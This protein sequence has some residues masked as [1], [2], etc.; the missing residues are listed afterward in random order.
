[1][2]FYGRE[3]QDR[4]A[5]YLIGPKGVFLDIGCHHPMQANNTM[6]LE[7]SGWDGL[8]F[9]LRERWVNLCKQYRRSEVFCVDAST[10]QFTDI[11]DNKLQSKLIDY[12]SLDADDG[13]L[14]A[15]RQLINKN[16]SFKCMTF[17]HDYYDKGNTIREPS[18]ALLEEV[19][20][21]LL[22]EDV[23]LPDGKIWEDWWIHPDHFPENIK[24]LY[25]KGLHFDEC[26]YKIMEYKYEN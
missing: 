9:D 23:R 13:T 14:G 16:Y 8:L 15:L 22:F 6:A 25:S 4:F 7:E 11:L 24:E 19:G 26:V 18:R 17:E 3:K 10:D 21:F 5:Y 1:M 2:R 20:Y 12:I